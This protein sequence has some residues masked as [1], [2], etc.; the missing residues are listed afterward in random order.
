MKKDRNDNR[1]GVLH[2]NLTVVQGCHQC[3]SYG[4]P[5]VLWVGPSGKAFVFCNNGCLRTWINEREERIAREVGQE[6]NDIAEE[7]EEY[8][9]TTLFQPYKEVRR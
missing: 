1:F 4:R 8:D 3:E 6:C 9:E 2:L 7:M 5:G